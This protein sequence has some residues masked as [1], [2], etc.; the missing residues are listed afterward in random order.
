[1]LDTVNHDDVIIITFLFSWGGGGGGYL[2]KL[3]QWL[4]VATLVVNRNS[5]KQCGERLRGWK[6]QLI[7][8]NCNFLYNTLFTARYW[9]WWNVLDVHPAIM[10]M[11]ENLSRIVSKV[12]LKKSDCR[13]KS[14]TPSHRIYPLCDNNAKEDIFHIVMQC[15]LSSNEL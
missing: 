15:N 5:L 9:T 3:F 1:M 13:L 11:C 4:E 14:L 10:R 7:N 8:D 2:L 12:N 6:I